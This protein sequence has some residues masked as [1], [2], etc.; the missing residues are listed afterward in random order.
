MDFK[1]QIIY[2]P[3]PEPG[4]H[5]PYSHAYVRYIL[6]LSLKNALGQA[7]ICR[8]LNTEARLQSQA[9][10]FGTSGVK[11]GATNGFFSSTSVSPCQHSKNTAYSTHPSIFDHI[12]YLSNNQLL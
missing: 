1:F 7:L 11:R 12:Y 10:S 6:I 9:C 8:L 2:L 3:Q 4:K 5:S